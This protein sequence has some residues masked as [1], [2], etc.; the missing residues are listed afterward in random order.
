MTT[1]MIRSIPTLLVFSPRTVTRAAGDL[2]SGDT[3][4][5]TGGHTPQKFMY[6]SKAVTIGVEGIG[7][8]TKP[9]VAGCT[10]NASDRR[11]A[12]NK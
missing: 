2:I 8:L 7:Y 5:R 4:G 3:A 12:G 6:L 10:G 11:T 1:A 9:P